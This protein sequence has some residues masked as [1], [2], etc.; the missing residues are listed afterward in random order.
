MQKTICL[1]PGDG[2]G[3]EIVAEAV[4]VLR[5][6][7]KKF[8]HSFTMTEALLGGAAI[9][10]EGRTRSRWAVPAR[11]GPGSAAPARPLRFPKWAYRISPP[12]VFEHK[13]L[14]PHER[15]LSIFRSLSGR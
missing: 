7:E 15:E 14:Y 12:V 1:L 3:P 2:I 6:V 9:G 11:P 5:A 10:A 8:G 4:K 13:I